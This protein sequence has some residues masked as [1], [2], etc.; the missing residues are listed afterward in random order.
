MSLSRSIRIRLRAAGIHFG[1][2]ALVAVLASLLVFFLWY[3]APYSS[4][5]GGLSLFVLLVSVDVVLGPALTAVAASPAKPRRE[6]LRDL[7]VIVVIQLI[8]FAYGMYT[9]A[10]ARPVHMV[11]EIDR[12]RVVTAADVEEPGLREA[13][14]ALRALPWTG[15]TLIA[16][17]KPIDPAEALR[18]VQLGLAG[19]DLA[20]V[21]RNWREMSAHAQAAWQAAKPLPQLLARYPHQ[22]ADAHAI[23]AR[24]GQ[25]PDSLRFLPLMS[26]H[27]SWTAVIAGPQFRVVGYLPVDAFI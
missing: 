4:I 11:F 1:A 23:A 2:S 3:P 12:L 10:I 21:P 15:P 20:M 9:I 17:V 13:P 8:A 18:S 14:P 25:N 6:F 19:I 22:A 5:A 16:A 24:I 7:S 27:A 26:R